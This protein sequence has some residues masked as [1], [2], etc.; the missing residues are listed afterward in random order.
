MDKQ[1]KKCLEKTI[2]TEFVSVYHDYNAQETIYVIPYNASLTPRSVKL[3]LIRAVG[4]DYSDKFDAKN[5]NDI[6]EMAS[7]FIV[8][9]TPEFSLTS[10]HFV[11]HNGVLMTKFVL[12]FAEE[13][14][15][16]KSYESNKMNNKNPILQLIRQCSNKIIAQEY[17]AQKHKMEKM[18]ISLNMFTQNVRHGRT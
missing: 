5:P 3:S 13:I 17:A 2:Q 11:N 9:I 12:D 14:L 10:S 7:N 8:G 4:F 15:F 16:E 1:L 6:D 18:F